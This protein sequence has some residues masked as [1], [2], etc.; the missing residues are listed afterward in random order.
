MESVFPVQKP[1]AGFF[2][3]R[4]FPLPHL[5][6]LPFTIYTHQNQHNIN[7][8][9]SLVFQFLD[10]VLSP[11]FLVSYTIYIYFSTKVVELGITKFNTFLNFPIL[12]K[13]RAHFD[14][15]P[16]AHI[17]KIYVQNLYICRYK[18]RN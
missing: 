8:H 12:K 9:S 6:L 3:T 17:H 7:I 5:S 14:L 18:K 15:S 1:E 13:R 4:C 16:Y 2:K 11:P 10:R